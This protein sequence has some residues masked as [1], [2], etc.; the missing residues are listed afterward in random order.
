VLIEGTTDLVGSYQRIRLTGTT[1]S[2][3]TGLPT[4]A[5]RELSV[6]E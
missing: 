5:G 2:T 3:F 1:G 4:V 6:I